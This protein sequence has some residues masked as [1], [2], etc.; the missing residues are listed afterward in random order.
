MSSYSRR[1]TYR[2]LRITLQDKGYSFFSN[3]DSEVILKAY[4]AWGE[5]CVK[6]FNGMFAFAIHER[7]T[8]RTVLARDRMGIKPLYF[9]PGKQGVRFA[10]SLPALLAAG[11]VDTTTDPIA[12][13]HYL[14][15]HAVVPPPF[16]ILKGIR[17]LPPATVRIYKK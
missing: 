5:H 1:S 12:L 4:H 17:K 13:H 11:E 14:H 10:S 7:D 15:W 9:R 3:G 2:E 8:G 6:R 16:T